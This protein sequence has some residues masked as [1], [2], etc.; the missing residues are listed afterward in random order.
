MRSR[1]ILGFVFVLL[2]SVAGFLFSSQSTSDFVAHLDRETHDI[3]C[4]VLPVGSAPQ[5]NTGCHATLMSPYSS[6]LR[7][8]VWGGIPIS[9]A[10]MGVFAFLTFAIVALI[11]AKKLHDPVA[12]KW[13]VIAWVVPALTSCVMGYLS[14]S[15]LQSLCKVC[16]MIYVS[17]AVGLIGA[18]VLWR[19]AL[20]P[21]PPTPEDFIDPSGET[22]PDARIS[23]GGGLATASQIETRMKA[24]EFAKKRPS[25][26][27]N[28]WAPFGIAMGI[29]FVAVPLVAYSANAPNFDRFVGSCDALSSTEDRHNILI[30][31]GPQTHAVTMIEVIDPLCAMCRGFER[32]FS[33]MPARNEVNRQ[34]LLF[35]LDHSC[36]WAVGQ[37]VHAGACDVT[38][39]ILCAERDAEAVL[40][41]AFDH[42]TEIAAAET[43]GEG[44]AR[45]MV[46]QQFPALASCI[47]SARTNLRLNQSLH[48]AVDNHL[49]LLTPQI[50][51]GTTRLCD[52]DTDL[53][54]DYMLPKLIE[55]ET[56]RSGDETP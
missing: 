42:Q 2:A 43:A 44:G 34:A 35:P 3:H 1:T 15:E 54:L 17:S 14:W 19:T 22:V 29:A 40:T 50:Y 48:W 25:P 38:R 11:L 39:A 21:V 53:G 24:G 41:W 26:M 49:P 37:T 23:P 18:I 28:A 20:S 9:L 52:A 5:A 10:S 47:G 33:Q 16:L 31:L 32:R 12:T 55:R 36:N 13:L 27:P 4:S 8:S 30:P 7:S 46:S 51:V 56:T 6:I 45:R